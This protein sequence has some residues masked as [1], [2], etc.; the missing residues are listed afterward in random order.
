MIFS[1]TI[2]MDLNV[3]VWLALSLAGASFVSVS[4][5]SVM[6]YIAGTFSIGDSNAI[7]VL[8][9]LVINWALGI[10]LM[11]HISKKIGTQRTYKLSLALL[12]MGSVA[13]GVSH[14]FIIML[15]ARGMQGI[16][17][18][19]LVPLAQVF[20]ISNIRNRHVA[21]SVWS[22]SMI[23]P[24][25]FGPAIAGFLAITLSYRLLFLFPVAIFIVSLFVVSRSLPV[26]DEPLI[27]RFDWLGLICLYTFLLSS[28]IVLSEG[29]RLGWFSSFFIECFMLI[30]LVS[31][32]VFISIENRVRYPLLP[33]R[34]FTLP[35]SI[36]L[37]GISVLWSLYMAWSTLILLVSG[38]I[39]S[40]NG[41][42]SG[43]VLLPC[44]VGYI[45]GTAFYNFVSKHIAHIYLAIASILFMFM[46]LLMIRVSPMSDARTL[47]FPLVFL[48]FS[49]AFMFVP[50]NL[51][52]FSGV[53]Q[54]N[55]RIAS[56]VSNFIRVYLSSVAVEILHISWQRSFAVF[57]ANANSMYFYGVLPS[58][59][60][61]ISIATK[62]SMSL[63]VNLCSE[64]SMAGCVFILILIIAFTYI[65]HTKQKAID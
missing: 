33:F 48:G 15:V 35:F 20:F 44:G 56:A 29:E 37:F 57:Y 12:I 64:A 38:Y 13:C 8:T 49:V 52:I 58:L 4:V 23:L 22:F 34:L 21:M 61:Q 55:H 45:L 25:F 65:T 5:Q 7:W 54:D 28:M 60:T 9:F 63:A 30:T 24:F 32:I 2:L 3:R 11:P 10:L 6:P 16:G 27:H 14:S 31:F 39:L 47:A 18:G 36:G 1:K 53:N 46:F 41:Y 62:T 42:Y 50:F 43:L 26:S 59:H 40:Y 17:A 19:L 51:I